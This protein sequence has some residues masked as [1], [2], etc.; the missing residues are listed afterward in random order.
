[1]SRSPQEPPRERG[2]QGHYC[3]GAGQ[4]GRTRS[5]KSR[6]ATAT[7]RPGQTQSKVACK[8]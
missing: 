6:P 5:A 1:M 2:W 3:K 4:P 8:E 7:S